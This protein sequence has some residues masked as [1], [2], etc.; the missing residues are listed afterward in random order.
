MEEI[1]TLKLYKINDM[2]SCNIEIKKEYIR[3]NALTLDDLFDDIKR[4]LK[5][6]N[7]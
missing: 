4:L 1:K 6:E 2:Y 3:I 7:F 5:D